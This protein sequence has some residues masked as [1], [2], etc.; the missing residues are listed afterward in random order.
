MLLWEDLPKQADNSQQKTAKLKSRE[1]GEYRHL[2]GTTCYMFFMLF[3]FYMLF[4][5]HFPHANFWMPC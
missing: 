3:M 1:A 2:E 4:M 5:F